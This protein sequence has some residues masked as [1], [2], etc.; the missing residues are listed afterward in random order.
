MGPRERSSG[1]GLK[2]VMVA[3][4]SNSS[5]VS[6]QLHGEDIA[7]REIRVKEEQRERTLCWQRRDHKDLF[8]RH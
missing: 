7:Q 8:Y 3:P 1:A 5:V 4:R 2:G 6:K